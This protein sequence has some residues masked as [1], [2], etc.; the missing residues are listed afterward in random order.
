M[1]TASHNP[2]EYNGFKMS[3]KGCSLFEDD[4]QGIGKIQ[5]VLVSD[6]YIKY[7]LKDFWNHYS[8]GKPLKVVWDCG[9]GATGDI[10][11]QLVTK[12]PGEHILLN[13]KVDGRFP[14]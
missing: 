7:M 11:E 14:A 9:N 8:K 5:R 13:Q 4:I 10:V 6:D 2:S 1:V 12:I 3:F